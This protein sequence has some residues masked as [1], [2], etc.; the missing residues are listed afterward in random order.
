MR[1]IIDE[2]IKVGISVL[3]DIITLLLIQLLL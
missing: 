2:M 1:Y 3:F